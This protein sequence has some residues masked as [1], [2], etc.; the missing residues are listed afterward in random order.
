M[1]KTIAAILLLTL[2]ISEQTSHFLVGLVGGFLYRA[3]CLLD[4]ATG[5]LSVEL[6]VS[7]VYSV[8]KKVAID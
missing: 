1:V 4:V 6:L 3:G 7:G 2:H 5:A 8:V